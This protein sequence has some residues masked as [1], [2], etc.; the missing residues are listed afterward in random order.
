MAINKL[1]DLT[2]AEIKHLRALGYRAQGIGYAK[3]NGY[4]ATKQEIAAALKTPVTAGSV[5]TEKYIFSKILQ[6]AIDQKIVP[7][8]TQDARNWFRNKALNLRA[9]RIDTNKLFENSVQMNKP[10]PGRMFMFNYDA[11]HKDTLPYWDAFPLIFMV[12]KAPK[13]FYGLNMHYLPPVLR[14][15]LMDALYT[16][17]QNQNAFDISTQ[18]QINYQTLKNASRFSLF[19]PCFKHYLFN[20]VGGDLIYV[21]PEEWDIALMLPTQRFQKASAQDVWKD[22]SK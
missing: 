5:T 21:E 8:K 20:N 12:D 15:K 3:P 16:K 14:A 10:L 9:G 17:V 22:S 18:L 6:K 4:M 19:K 13:G 2:D 11:E 7:N 1:Y